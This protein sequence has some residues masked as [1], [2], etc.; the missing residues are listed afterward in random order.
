MKY[1]DGFVLAVPKDKFED[2]KKMAKDA[3]RTWKKYGALEYFECW[4][5]DL[6]PDMKGMKCLIFPE[7][8]NL[9]KNEDVWF[10]FIVYKSKAHRDSVNKKVMKHFEDNKEKYKDMKMP[11][12]MNRM[13]YGGFKAVVEQ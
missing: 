8:I 11:F 6:N 9:N 2:Y 13:A 3:A 7:L 5:D 10:S 12:E 4:G 1:V